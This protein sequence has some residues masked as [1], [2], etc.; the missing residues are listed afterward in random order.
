MPC[1]YTCLNCLGNGNE[2]NHQ[3]ISCKSE[4]NFTNDFENDTN[5]YEICEYYY[6]DSD[7]NYYCTEY[8]R[9]PSGYNLLIK[10]KKKC[11]SNCSFNNI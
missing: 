2:S 1:Y 8:Y 11:K 10:D 7:N 6:F 5:C 3:C 4:Y 9:C